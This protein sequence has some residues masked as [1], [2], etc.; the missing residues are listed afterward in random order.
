MTIG[1]TTHKNG[2]SGAALV[3]FGLL[4]NKLTTAISR[5]VT[6][7]AWKDSVTLAIHA[8]G[9]KTGTEAE[10]AVNR[11]F[12]DVKRELQ[13]ASILRALDDAGMGGLSQIVQVDD[14]KQAVPVKVE[15]RLAHLYGSK[16]RL[17]RQVKAALDTAENYRSRIANAIR[18][19]VELEAS[20][21]QRQLDEARIKAEIEALPE[22]VKAERIAKAEGVKNAAAM[23]DEFK[24]AILGNDNPAVAMIAEL[25]TTIIVSADSADEALQ[26]G[27]I[28]AIGPWAAKFDTARKAA[29][30]SETPTEGASEGEGESLANMDA[31]PARV[32]A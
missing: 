24:K 30:G 11:A 28:Q 2:L 20:M 25:L 7:N 10:D 22:D 26:D 1:I 6:S 15:K 5:N 9:E 23:A 18:A 29:Q 8:I 19:G 16:F 4:Q 27:F 3:A 32:A 12:A 21:T 31:E 13:S 17:D 14:G